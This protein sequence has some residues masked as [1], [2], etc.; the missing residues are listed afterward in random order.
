MI[1]RFGWRGLG[2]RQ[3]EPGDYTLVVANVDGVSVGES[4]SEVSGE[5]PI[6]DFEVRK[7]SQLGENLIV[8]LIDALP[9]TQGTS[10]GPSGEATAVGSQTDNKLQDSLIDQSFKGQKQ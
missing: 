10:V 5:L 3:P 6:G 8:G 2:R 4:F 1:E 9:K 7:G